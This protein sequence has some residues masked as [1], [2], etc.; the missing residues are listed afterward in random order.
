MDESFKNFNPD[1]D[2]AWYV[3][4]CLTG[5]DGKVFE[6]LV[7]K[8]DNL[9]WKEIF[10]EVVQVRE[11]HITE[12]TLKSGEKKKKITYQNLYPGYIFVHCVMNDD[13]WFEIRNTPGVMGIIGSHG[14]GSKPT[15]M[16]DNEVRHMLYLAGKPEDIDYSVY[17]IGSLI[18]IKEGPFKGVK[19]EIIDVNYDI[20][21]ATLSVGDRLKIKV[22]LEK[23]ELV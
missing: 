16:T 23:V 14:K 3:I 19:S 22:P 12:R 20:N 8:K 15:P 9:E 11:E 6:A 13:L 1:K 4:G 10:H 18:Q 7:A 21:I 17:K 2:A 5:R